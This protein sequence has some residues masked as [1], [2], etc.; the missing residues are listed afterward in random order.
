MKF[1]FLKHTADVKFRA[2]GK[3]LSE[4]F[5]NSAAAMFN[6]MYRG[7]VNSKLKKKINVSGRD[8]ESLLYNFLEELLFLVDSE[9]F[10]VS[11]TKI[12]IDEKNFKLEAE[13][14][15]DELLNYEISIDIKAITYN[16]MFVKKEN[17]KWVCQV[18]VDV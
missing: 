5:E 11:K 2:Y 16:E 10:F 9:N 8:L 17:G 3:T 6:S 12:K 15:G 1:K 14:L 13:L 4:A 7:K 18:V